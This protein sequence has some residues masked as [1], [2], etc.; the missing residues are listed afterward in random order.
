[1]P[2]NRASTGLSTGAMAGIIAGSVVGGLAILVLLIVLC[3][4][5]RRSRRRKAE[6]QDDIRWP[7]I[8]ASADDRAALYP[9]QTHATGR[10][11]IGGEEMEEVGEGSPHSSGG[12]GAAGI[13]AG[14][15]GRRF[16]SQTSRDGDSRQPTLPS[17]PASVYS[18]MMNPT[19]L[20]Y[21]NSTSSPYGYSSSQQSHMPLAPGPAS[22]DY[23]RNSPSPPSA[24]NTGSSQGHESAPIPA[25]EELSHPSTIHRPSSPTDM[26]VGAT[27]GGGYDESAPGKWRLSVVND[28]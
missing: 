14:G 4:A 11:G 9:E 26:Q 27:Y 8:V 2:D 13:G 19:S 23:Q 24:A 16:N 20:Q 6:A 5:S 17:L 25:V 18:D 15:L 22:S 7:E 21:S 3:L 28:A 12:P 1:M 10:A